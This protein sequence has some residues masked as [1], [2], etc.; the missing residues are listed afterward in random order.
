[1]D[2]KPINNTFLRVSGLM[3]LDG[4]VF[5]LGD[6]VNFTLKGSIVSVQE[7]DNQDGTRDLKFV[8]KATEVFV[9]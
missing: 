3:S 2:N 1:M 4:A 6:D 9:K 7:G 5:K 8:F